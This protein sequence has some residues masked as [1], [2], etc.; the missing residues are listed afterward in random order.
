MSETLIVT[1]PWHLQ[2]AQP[3]K[4][5]TMLGPATDNLSPSTVLPHIDLL[6]FYTTPF[7]LWSMEARSSNS[8]MEA[9]PY[10]WT[11]ESF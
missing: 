8:L 1:S 6:F 7:T 3:R 10:F 9:Y 5:L 4:V 2:E 11:K